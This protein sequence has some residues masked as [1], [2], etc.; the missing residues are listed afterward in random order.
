MVLTVTVMS[1]LSCKGAN[2]IYVE[3]KY[4]CAYPKSPQNQRLTLCTTITQVCLLSRVH[5]TIYVEPTNQLKVHTLP[6]ITLEPKTNTTYQSYTFG[7]IMYDNLYRNENVVVVVM[8]VRPSLHQSLL[9]MPKEQKG[10]QRERTTCQRFCLKTNHGQRN[11]NKCR[12][13]EDTQRGG[14]HEAKVITWHGL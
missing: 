14:G 13:V 12:K 3:T 11:K 7:P 8:V 6:K 5:P 2:N 4:Q 10:F 9:F 1:L